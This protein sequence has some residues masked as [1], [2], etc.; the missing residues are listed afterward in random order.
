VTASGSVNQGT[1]PIRGKRYFS[2]KIKESPA[3][4]GANVASSAV[5]TV[6]KRAGL[7]IWPHHAVLSL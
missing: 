7:W 3:W 6:G 1:I 2:Y 4:H 5:L